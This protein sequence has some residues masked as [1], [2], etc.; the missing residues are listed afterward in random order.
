MTTTVTKEDLAAAIAELTREEAAA[1]GPVEARVPAGR[2]RMDG[3]LTICGEQ[4]YLKG[5][6]DSCSPA[7]HFGIEKK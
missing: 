3:I 4:C 6:S 2:G 5:A 1:R 7:D